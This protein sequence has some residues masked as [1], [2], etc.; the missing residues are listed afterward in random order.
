MTTCSGICVDLQ[1]DPTNCGACGVH[2]AM[3]QA[4]LK[5]T[6]KCAP[7]ETSCSGLCVDLAN[8]SNNCGSCGNTCTAGTSCKNSVCGTCSACA[9]TCYGARCVETLASGLDFPADLVVDAANVYWTDSVEKTVTSEP[10]A[11]GAQSVLVTASGA[12]NL[13]VDAQYVYY[14]T[15]DSVEKVP[16]AG[17]MRTV[18]AGALSTPGALAVDADY[19]YWSAP[20]Q[21]SVF[22]A[23]LSG[24]TPVPIVTGRNNPAW[25]AVDAGTLYWDEGS[26]NGNVVNT[27]GAIM[28]IPLAGGPLSALAT[29]LNTPATMQLYAGYVYFILYRDVVQRVSLR[30]GVVETLGTNS[31]YNNG[32]AVDATGVYVVSAL[33]GTLMHVPLAGGSIATLIEGL[34]FPR[35]VAVDATYIYWA[36]TTFFPDTTM[37]SAI[38]RT[39]KM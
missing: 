30:G 17:G 18:L 38:V 26:P 24:G 10:L 36:N 11:G 20:T 39:S 21:G 13:T 32:L 33:S 14:G 12:G 19:I 28:S 6:C 7:S 9:G 1:T 25:I 8:D 16:I 23:P 2:C 35:S 5:G 4:C 37:S 3:T 29:G 27:D 34:N 31:G 22:K 15:A